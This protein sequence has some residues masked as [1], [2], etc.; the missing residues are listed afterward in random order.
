MPFSELITVFS[1]RSTPF[2]SVNRCLFL[3]RSKPSQ[4]ITVFSISMPFRY[5]FSI[6]LFEFDNSLLTQCGLSG[7]YQLLFC[8]RS[9]P[10][11]CLFD[12]LSQSFRLIEFDALLFVSMLYSESITVFLIRST[13]FSMPFLFDQI[14]FN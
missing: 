12:F 13:L 14:I 4:S 3:F 9:S 6:C 7:F 8:V 1:I 11:R 2:R 10:L 5:A